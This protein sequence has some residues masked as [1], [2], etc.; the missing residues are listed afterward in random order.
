MPKEGCTEHAAQDMRIMS[1]GRVWRGGSAT[2]SV[3]AGM[4]RG[5]AGECYHS[6]D[7]SELEFTLNTPKE[8]PTR[9]RKL[10]SQA[11]HSV[12]RWETGMMTRQRV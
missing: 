4:Q 6:A 9:P 5:A 2:A 12:Q 10:S 1:P 8:L 3:I 7:S 11:G